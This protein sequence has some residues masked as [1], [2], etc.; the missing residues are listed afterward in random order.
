M[1]WDEFSRDGTSGFTGDKPAD[2]LAEALRRVSEDY[3][4]RFARKPTVAEVLYGLE[5]V[6]SAQPKRFVSDHEGL[7]GGR[8]AMTRPGARA[9]SLPDSSAY[10]ASYSPDEGGF[11]AIEVRSSG[12][13]VAR[14]PRIEVVG[15]TL[16]VDFR[17]VDSSISDEGAHH[18]VI[19]L[20]LEGL[21]QGAYR[22]DAERIRFSNL[23]TGRVDRLPYS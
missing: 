10:E 16:E 12:R 3:L 14:V 7:Q 22:A 17:I 4:D 18:L 5:R 15:D 9:V 1:G 11:Y 2:H 23:D 13:D 8:I 6:L 19:T 21:S 20:I